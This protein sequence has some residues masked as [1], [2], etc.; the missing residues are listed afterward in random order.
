MAPI[1]TV[2]VLRFGEVIQSWARYEGGKIDFFIFTIFLIG[3]E[4]SAQKNTIAFSMGPLLT[5]GPPAR[6]HETPRLEIRTS[7]KKNWK[8][9]PHRFIP[10]PSPP[11]PASPPPPP[12]PRDGGEDLVAVHRPLVRAQPRRRLL[13]RA[14]RRTLPPPHPS[15]LVLYHHLSSRRFSRRR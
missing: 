8:K 15:R 5:W 2:L 11:S 10:K 14:L 1:W 12:P 3:L 9:I 4:C 13:P 6:N 7:R